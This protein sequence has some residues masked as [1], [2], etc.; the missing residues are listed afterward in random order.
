MWTTAQPTPS[1]F[2]LYRSKQ[3]LRGTFP[4]TWSLSPVILTES[5]KVLPNIT[6]TWFIYTNDVSTVMR[7]LYPPWECG[8][9]KNRHVR[10]K[11][12]WAVRKQTVQVTSKFTTSTLPN[13]GVISVIFKS[14]VLGSA[15]NRKGQRTN[16][17]YWTVECGVSRTI[18]YKSRCI[19]PN[20]WGESKYKTRLKIYHDT[21]C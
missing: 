16:I 11:F 5:A 14:S 12:F 10:T 18:S 13:D 8:N 2:I 4:F 21:K 3:Y 17:S 20:P 7:K 19:L 15:K 6:R 1:M 9:K